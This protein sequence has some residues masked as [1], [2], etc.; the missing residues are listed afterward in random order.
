[1]YLSVVCG[2]QDRVDSAAALEDIHLR[3]LAAAGALSELEQWSFRGGRVTVAKSPFTRVESQESA[4]A[5][6]LRIIGGWSAPA[7]SGDDLWGEYLVVDLGHANGSFSA[8]IRSNQTGSWPCFA[9]SADGL[10]AIGNDPLGLARMLNLRE[11]EPLTVASIL[12][13]KHA[14]GRSTSVKGIDR[15]W[16]GEIAK[17]D[18]STSTGA[19]LSIEKYGSRPAPY[20]RA[21]RKPIETFERLV[22]GSAAA[23]TALG[24]V[25]KVVQISGGLDSR[26]SLAAICRTAPRD[27]IS[28]LTMEFSDSTEMLIAEQ[29]CSQLGVDHKSF[30]MPTPTVDDAILGWLLTGGQ[31]PGITAA[32][33][34]FL[35]RAAAQSTKGPMVVFG[36]WP[37]DCLIGSYVP[38][39]R[40][41][42]DPSRRLQAIEMWTRSRSHVWKDMRRA[43]NLGLDWG[44]GLA[45]QLLSSVLDMPGESAGQAV[46]QW[47][48]YR[49]QPTFSYLQ[50][51]RLL[52]SV[53]DQTPCV[54]PSY[55]EE[56]NNLSSRQIIGK[57]Y[58]RAMLVDVSPDLASIKY[59]GT[60]R[61]V[62]RQQVEPTKRASAEYR[63]LNYIRRSPGWIQKSAKRVQR[64]TSAKSMTTLT[65]RWKFVLPRGVISTSLGLISPDEISDPNQALLLRSAALN[66]S[67]TEEYLATGKLPSIGGNVRLYGQ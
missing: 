5:S 39:S 60:G 15:V 66:I 37:G 13:H 26:F 57:N 21:A 43:I 6:L 30:D 50:P 9:G 42:L 32:A 41:F 25:R 22:E 2:P 34:I 28:A 35:Y 58:Y 56:L 40:D 45:S 64:P 62:S 51:S 48:M 67:W 17:L 27:E 65:D 24:D 31:I 59:H 29:I 18:G 4:H 44:N 52:D 55:L 14:W 49:R 12:V 63:L 61:I 38:L 11:V 10:V 20:T 33:N 1:M 36:A 47:A 54:W 19:E 8:S 46:S 3:V 7:E 53:L 16:P 23:W